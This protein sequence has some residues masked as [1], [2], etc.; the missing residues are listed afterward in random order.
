M[1]VY[2]FYFIFK[3]LELLVEEKDSWVLSQVP[4]TTIPEVGPVNVSN[5]D[6]DQESSIFNLPVPD[7]TTK[8]TGESYSSYS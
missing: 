6:Q 7:K 4:L 8:K 2:S 3:N 5:Q 1:N